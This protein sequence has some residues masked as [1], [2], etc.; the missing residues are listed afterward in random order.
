MTQ[1]RTFLFLVLL[2]STLSTFG[3]QFSATVV[4]AK[5]GQPIPFAT[6]ETGKNQGVI[7][8]EEGVF[9]F[10]ISSIR[11]PL[12][13]VYVSSMGYA[14]LGI[15]LTAQP[16]SEIKLT[17]TPFTLKSVYVS[18]SNLS[19]K[20]IIEKVKENMSA[21]YATSL[22]RKK[23]FFRQ[24]DFNTMDKVDF[25]FQKSTI[26]ELNKELI[27]SIAGLIPRKSSYYREVAGEFYGDY[28]THKFYV[29]KAA[30]L[31]DKSK[32]V[33]FDG[34]SDKLERI[35]KENV[36]PDS[37][38]KIKSGIFGTKLQLDSVADANEEEAKVVKVQVED[39]DHQN[40]SQQ[41]KDRISEL[42]E[43]L[44]FHEDSKLD[45]LTKSNRYRFEQEGYTFIEGEPVFVLTFEPK[46]KKDFKGVMYVDTEDF[47]IVRLDFQNVR[48]LKR[49]GLLGIKY[50]NNVFR[51]KMLFSKN[52]EGT[53]SPR[54]LEL[55][56]GSFF[57]VA[58]P[59]KVIEKNKHVKG[60]R[61]QN[62]LSLELDV[63][64]TN[65][66]KYEMVVFDSETISEG[67]YSSVKENK[68][69]KAQYLSKYDPNFWAGYTIMEPNAAI[70]EF[71]V[72][73]E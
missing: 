48:P 23:I 56:N 53:Y 47:A 50:R 39:T 19:P 55:E 7:T 25:G 13:S 65:L 64:T 62:E 30:E 42:Y 57:G 17:P 36:K 54:Y 68:D 33:S 27:D 16:A 34:L 66:N 44:F 20:E 8:N 37:Y 67:A 32:D 2:S 40:F 26:E 60:R 3:Q 10:D 46:G 14:R 6:V 63:Q 22:S 52:N 61:K 1:I 31:Y 49:F 12:D 24:S 41:I 38:I 72:V 11:E 21:N 45:M 15:E 71:T 28:R 70:Q 43:Q 5:T 29:D 59:L 73:D 35:F 69:V 58:R 9:S 51:G 18:N 4:D